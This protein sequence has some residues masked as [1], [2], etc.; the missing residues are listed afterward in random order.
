MPSVRPEPSRRTYWRSLDELADTPRYRAWVEAE[1]PEAADPTGMNRRRWMQLMGASLTLAGMAGCRWEKSEI[2]PMA[3]QPADRTPGVPQQFASAMEW[4]GAALGLMVTS[5]DGRPIK[6]EGNPHHPQSLGATSA[7]AQAAILELYDPDR[8]RHLI[9]RAGGQEIQ[10]TWAEFA[11][12]LRRRL[13]GLGPAGAGL[14]VLAGRSSSPTRARLQAALA[15]R[16]PG[17]RWYE[18]EPVSRDSERQATQLAFG[19]PLRPHLHADRADILVC[20][21]ADLFLEHPNAVRYAR[22]FA[23]SRDPA[24]KPMIRL[25]AVESTF[26]LTGAL[27]DH[28]LP[29]RSRQIPEWVA[30]LEKVLGGA[31]TSPADGSPASRFLAAVATDLG[32][33]RG[34]SIVLAG[35]RQSAE[36]QAAVFRINHALGNLGKTITFTAEPD[37]ERTVSHGEAIRNLVQD[38]QAGQV[39]TLLI[40]GGNPAYDAPGDVPF[41]ETLVR[42]PTSIHLGLYRNETS[43]C[44]AWHLPQAHFL[45]SW[46]DARAY[47]GTYTLIQPLIEPLWGGKSEIELLGVLLGE[48]AGALPLVQATFR[49]I[50]GESD[51]ASRWPRAVQQGMADGTAWPEEAVELTATAAGIAVSGEALEA[52][53]RADDL[54]LVIHP[55]ARVFDGRFANNAWLQEL[56]DPIT[57][58]VWDNAAVMGLATAG[59]LRVQDGDLVRLVRGEASVV[60]PVLILP[61]VAA[62]TIAAAMGYGRTAAGQV[63]G[64]TGAGV[65]PVGVDVRPLRI[66]GSQDGTGGVSVR[67]EAGEHPVA[68]TQNHHAIDLVGIRERTGRV[69]EL[70]RE[71]DLAHYQ[72]HPDFAQHLVHHKPL[73]SLWNEPDHQGHRWAMAI[74]LNRCLGCGACV[75]ACQAENNVPIVG[76]DQVLVGR[77]MHWLRVDRYFRSDVDV[78]EAA[79]APIPCMQCELAPCESV[80]PVAATVHSREGL[81]DMVYNRCVGTRYCG[82]NCPYKVRRFNYLSFHRDLDQPAGAVRKMAYNPEVTIRSRGVMEKCTYCVQRIQNA[83]IQAKREGQPVADGAIRTA[84]QQACP[85]QAIVFGDLNDPQSAVRKLQD[86][87]RC[88]RMLEELNTKPRTG[89][90]ARVRNPSPLLAAKEQTS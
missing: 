2:V 66:L 52:P 50:A 73:E 12:F 30:Q 3:E 89:Y 45:E 63:G 31:G 61:G 19:R 55:D 70:L 65:A 78:P 58:A 75:V 20:L 14:C 5:Y 60:L 18:Y 26:S 85:A 38:I 79:F 84:C 16:F 4:Q 76:R 46:G 87:P 21:D 36:V 43:L 80:C 47:D 35:P 54:E 53:F 62:G 1:F 22:D 13:D 42:V 29:L 64:L 37:P 90:L 10:P 15:Q 23:A 11:T 71:A 24:R 57:Q 82:N 83:K 6:I 81:N 41:A 86:E 34:R 56:P 88:Y 51:F 17:A 48:Q 72:Q 9:R 33:H 40:L 25:Y 77:E 59:A 32:N 68:T 44:C 49:S 74:D 69:G 8:S 28:R 67:V 7:L 27:A 39:D